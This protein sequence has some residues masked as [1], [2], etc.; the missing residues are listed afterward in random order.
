MIF[1]FVTFSSRLGV[2]EKVQQTMKKILVI[3]N[4]HTDLKYNSFLY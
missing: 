3:S 2:W 1:G 4:Y